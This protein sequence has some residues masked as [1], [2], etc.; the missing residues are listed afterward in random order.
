MQF[1]QSSVLPVAEKST[2]TLIYRGVRY[3]IPKNRIHRPDRTAEHMAAL[4]G[5]ELVYHGIRYKLAPACPLPTLTKIGLRLT[6]RGVT[7]DISSA[8]AS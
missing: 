6:Y 5:K 2:I 8:V 1:V 3:E 4:M 7:Y